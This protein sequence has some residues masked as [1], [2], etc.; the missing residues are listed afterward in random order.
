MQI[1]RCTAPP[2]AAT[3]QDADARC[4]DWARQG[5]C[6]PQW[7]YTDKGVAMHWCR[8]TCGACDAPLLGSSNST[9]SAKPSNTTTAKPANSTT[10]KPANSTTAKPANSTAG[11]GRSWNGTLVCLRCTAASPCM[12]G[13][14]PP[15][16]D[17]ATKSAPCL[18]TSRRRRSK[19]TVQGFERQVHGLGCSQV[20]RPGMEYR[21]REHRKPLVQGL[22]HKGLRP[23][24]R[25]C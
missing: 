9:V 8:K 15:A 14:A 24:I 11:K 25:G 17:A 4:A 19:A 16:C 2:P 1:D 12:T 23:A 22:L 5:Y 3:C 10:A 7:A 13:C 18:P 6:A 20:L 21:R